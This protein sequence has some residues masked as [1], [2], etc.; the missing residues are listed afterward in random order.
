M[1]PGHIL[2]LVIKSQ[3]DLLPFY[4]TNVGNNIIDVRKHIKQ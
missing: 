3:T 2:L 4:V 1:V